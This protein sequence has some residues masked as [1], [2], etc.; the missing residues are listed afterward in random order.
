MVSQ[1][2]QYQNPV[3]QK[4]GKLD[5][6]SQTRLG[7]YPPLSNFGIGSKSISQEITFSKDVQ[8]L[9]TLE[10]KM[11][12]L[13]E[14]VG[15]RLRH[16]HLAAGTVRIKLRWSD[17]T[18]ITRQAHLEQPTNQDHILIEAAR[19]LLRANFSG[20]Q[21]VR[22]IGVGASNLCEPAYQLA[23]FDPSG[24]KERKLLSTLDELR[25]RYGDKVI[26]KGSKISSKGKP[27]SG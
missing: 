27:G 5:G 20:G 9:R 18:T 4:T 13:A 2:P 11:E 14:Q 3:V 19:Q 7:S 15:Y 25:D 1:A 26:R 17:F 24:E 22:L 21:P 12:D 10:K 8:D 6:F 16:Q 23:L